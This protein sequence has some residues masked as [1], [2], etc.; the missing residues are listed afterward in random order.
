MPRTFKTGPAFNY[1]SNLVLNMK[2]NRASSGSASGLILPDSSFY[3]NNAIV[4]GAPKWKRG[5]FDNA[6]DM[7]GDN[8][9]LE[10]QEDSSLDIKGDFTLEVLA[11]QNARS[12]A[13]SLISKDSTA[14]RLEVGS[15]G[16]LI[17]GLSVDGTFENE[18]VGTT[19]LSVGTQY[20]LVGTYNSS[21]GEAKVY[22]N[23][24]L[25]STT[26]YGTGG[27]DRN[28]KRLLVGAP[29]ENARSGLWDGPIEFAR[30]YT[31]ALSAD[32]IHER[33]FSG[34]ERQSTRRI[35]ISETPDEGNKNID[36]EYLK[37][38]ITLRHDND[39]PSI[40][41]MYHRSI[42]WGT[43]AELLETYAAGQGDLVLADRNRAKYLAKRHMAVNELRYR[44]RTRHQVIKGCDVLM[45]D[46]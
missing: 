37:K 23:K 40:D 8:D 25:E 46:I 41:S 18:C 14:Y 13:Q 7:D 1:D 22:V 45:E 3:S 29:F 15:G 21:T 5:T 35:T 31:R 38:N 9:Y 44:D 4:K 33:H 32:E 6:L 28:N 16:T 10:I 43:L 39:V 36:I 11:T 19:I 17:L 34:A 12:T 2:L 20:H 42:I 24:T 27:P 26:A 30:V